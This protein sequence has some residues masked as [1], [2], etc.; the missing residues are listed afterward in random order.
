MATPTDSAASVCVQWLSQ[1]GCTVLDA[2][3]TGLNS[4]FATSLLG[5][6]AGAVAGAV[7]AQRIVE[8]YRARE[9]AIR[10]LRNTNAAALAAFT[11][12]NAALM[13]K[14]QH[15]L[16]LLNKFKEQKAVVEEH[17]A[18]VT[19][20]Q[21]QGSG[22]IHFETDMRTFPA[23]L[24]PVETLKDLLFN[25]ISVG[26]RTLALVCAVEDASHGL[27]RTMNARNVLIGRMNSGE[28]P[29]DVVPAYYFGLR[30]P[31]GDINQEYPDLT[32]ATASYCD[33][34]AFFSRTLC[35][36]LISHANAIHSKLT[37]QARNNAPEP[38]KVDFSKAQESGLIPSD[39]QYIDWLRAF[40]KKVETST[41]DKAIPPAH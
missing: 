30:L 23:P 40:P 1:G 34:L 29:K 27:Q 35:L 6:L 41:T 26:G 10:E 39:A 19:A 11:T 4:S 12:C 13:L 33:D 20:G 24:V 7:A 37:K 22:R 14:K 5:S 15:V 21:I 18:K 25:K 31:N 9:D 28:I 16:P 17:I 32:F 36:D 2:I 38:V 8:R 3:G